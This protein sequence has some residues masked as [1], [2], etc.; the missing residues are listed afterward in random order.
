L[1]NRESASRS[2]I[3]RLGFDAAVSMRR[4]GIRSEPAN[5]RRIAS[6]ARR[7]ASV[8]RRPRRCACSR[9][10]SAREPTRTSANAAA[11]CGGATGGRTRTAR[12]T[13]ALPSTG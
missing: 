10:V 13:G 1:G 5:H 12:G 3:P 6:A 8:D 11:D 2:T 4:N 9:R 7:F